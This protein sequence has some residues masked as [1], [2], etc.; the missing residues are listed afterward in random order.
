MHTKVKQIKISNIQP[1]IQKCHLI[2][3]IIYESKRGCAAMLVYIYIFIYTC[4]ISS[5]QQIPEDIRYGLLE[6]F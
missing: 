3:Y 4:I 2:L 5:R 1:R 6:T